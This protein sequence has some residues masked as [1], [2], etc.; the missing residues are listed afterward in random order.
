LAV[1]ALID[2]V[3]LALVI[4]GALALAAAQHGVGAARAAL[5]S[6]QPG[7]GRA[8]PVDEAAAAAR[9]I[10][11]ADAAVGHRGLFAAETLAPRHSFLRAALAELADAR[12]AD[13][14]ADRMAG[15]G[16][17]ATAIDQQPVRFWAAVAD[18]APA[19]GMIGTVAGMIGM[20]GG[21]GDPEQAAPSLALALTSTLYGLV[22]SACIAAP[23]A[24]R[25]QQRVD[26]N[27]RWRDK[28]AAALTALVARETER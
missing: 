16:K 14:F 17:A 26:A 2:P 8:D 18:A 24:E 22:L 6:V 4:G 7:S 12:A 11:A 19:L 27:A 28:L 21:P 25:A 10:H 13:G 1:N 15:L 20:A 5:T 23:L 9:L 3:S